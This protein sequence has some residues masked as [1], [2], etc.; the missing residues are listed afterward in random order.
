MVDWNEQRRETR[1]ARSFESRMSLTFEGEGNMSSTSYDRQFD[2]PVCFFFLSTGAQRKYV[3][4]S[5]RP[6]CAWDLLYSERTLSGAEF[7]LTSE[8]YSKRKRVSVVF[9]MTPYDLCNIDI[10]IYMYIYRRVRKEGRVGGLKGV[11]VASVA[12]RVGSRGRAPLQ[13]NCVYP[14]VTLRGEYNNRSNTNKKIPL[15]CV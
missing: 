4:R 2:F 6:S 7:L 1:W 5:Y 13:S 3:L 11:E 10:Y 12:A 8:Y 15:F 14:F 9:D